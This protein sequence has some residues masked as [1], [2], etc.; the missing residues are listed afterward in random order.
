MTKR[1]TDQHSLLQQVATAASNLAGHDRREFLR[2]GLAV[3][4]GGAIINHAGAD[5]QAPPAV[6]P[7]TRSLGPG[8]EGLLDTRIF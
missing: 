3:A 1:D 7:W 6:P 4:A 5:Q 2:R 8:G